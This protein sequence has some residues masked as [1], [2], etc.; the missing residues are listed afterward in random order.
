MK[1]IS[2]F[3][4]LFISLQV[5]AQFSPIKNS[6]SVSW[7]IKHEIWDRAVI[8]SL[9]LSDTISLNK[10]QYYQVN[11]IED[12]FDKGLVGYFREDSLAGKAWFWGLEDSTE[13]LIMDLSLRKG[14]SIFVKMVYGKKYAHVVNVEIENGRKTITTDYH[15][16]G[17]FIS[18]YLKFIE[19]V[20]PNATVL[21]QVDRGMNF[22]GGF[23]VCKAFH[24]NNLIYAWDSISFGCGALWDNV[25]FQ[26]PD[27]VKIFPNPASKLL[28]IS[29]QGFLTTEIFDMMG[30]L[31]L[32]TNDN[33]VDIYRI[34]GGVYVVKVCSENK[35]IKT[36][37][38]II[39]N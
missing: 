16:G 31:V 12:D 27:Q 9:Y 36:D 23:L 11:I 25:N 7:T 34:P 20:G 1:L 4:L 14:D 24:D 19:G 28:M 39:S 33:R 10:K 13:Y 15:F 2:L 37:K 38:L 17:G 22:Q 21:Y 29:G 18:E 8:S 6:D 30:K 32:R 3:V 26:T 35:I 5:K